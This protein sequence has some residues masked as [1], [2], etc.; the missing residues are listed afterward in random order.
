MAI[1]F[2]AHLTPICKIFHEF[3]ALMLTYAAL[4][5]IKKHLRPCRDGRRCNGFYD[6]RTF[7]IR[8]LVRTVQP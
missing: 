3:L 4:E 8:L 1:R 5:L 6:I 2:E 7:T